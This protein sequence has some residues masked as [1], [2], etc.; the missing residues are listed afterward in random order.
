MIGKS[1]NDGGFENSI[2]QLFFRQKYLY[3]CACDLNRRASSFDKLSQIAWGICLVLF[4]FFGLTMRM[5]GMN[6]VISWFD[7]NQIT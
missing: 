4:L 7:S 3:L 2:Y 1:K 6:D 5:N